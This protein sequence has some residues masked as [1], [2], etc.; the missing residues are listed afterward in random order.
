M[1]VGKI[2]RDA[3]HQV[4]VRDER[5]FTPGNTNSFLPCAQRIRI[6]C[7]ILP[8]EITCP[9]PDST[10]QTTSD[11]FE[12][13]RAVSDA[14]RARLAQ[15][16][17]THWVV[18]FLR[19]DRSLTLDSP[20][21]RHGYGGIFALT[22][23]HAACSNWAR[24]RFRC[25][26]CLDVLTPIPVR[27]STMSTTSVARGRYIVERIAV[28]LAITFAL[29]C[30]SMH[31][32]AGV[33]TFC[34]IGPCNFTH[35]TYVNVYWDS[36]P[37]KWDTDVGGMSRGLTQ[38]QLDAFTTALVR[39]SYSASSAIWRG[40]RLV[41]ARHYD[42]QLRTGSEKRGRCPQHRSSHPLCVD[43][44]RGHQQRSSDHQRI[45]AAA[46]AEHGVVTWI[47]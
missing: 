28:L 36:S 2:K 4:R 33:G 30:A 37:S 27:G 17:S 18:D 1:K 21:Q 43:P 41:P 16:P 9:N 35:P 34:P 8:L 39:S 3:S 26:S 13:R 25:M 38:A 40:V 10:I 5:S 24:R 46:G 14:G 11:G 45:P 23:D 22:Q 12:L 7:R 31:A 6:A 42:R 44:S 29:L 32:S 20:T 19:A 47:R 15:T